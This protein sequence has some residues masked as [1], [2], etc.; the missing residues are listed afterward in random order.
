MKLIIACGIFMFV[1]SAQTA[2]IAVEAPE[3]VELEQNLPIEGGEATKTLLFEVENNEQVD[4]P[5]K[6]L[7]RE[8]RQFGFGLGGFGIGIGLGGGYPYY[9]GYGGG[10]GYPGAYGGYGG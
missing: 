5:T 3:P 1:A 8:K 2:T 9:G 7:T 4:D 6:E 10:Y